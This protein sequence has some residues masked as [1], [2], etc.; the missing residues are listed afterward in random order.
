MTLSLYAQYLTERTSRGILETEDG[1]AT[2]DYISDDTVYIIDL[3]VVPEK[4][5]SHV[6]SEIAN[7]ICE[8]A[9]KTGRKYLLGS[10]D[11]TAK[12]SEASCKVL[13]AYGMT[14]H[15]VAEP[16]IF[17]VKQIAEVEIKQEIEVV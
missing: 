10:V 8:E 14:I 15:K 5:K 9:I 1:F 16:M 11:V 2:F 17:Y 12:G 3:F 4:R 13:E 7:K 6:A